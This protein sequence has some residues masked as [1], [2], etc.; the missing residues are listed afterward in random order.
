MKTLSTLFVAALFAFSM[1]GCSNMSKTGK[2]AVI[3]TG[4][5]A[6]AGAAIGKAAGDATKG[7]II[8]AVVGGSAGAIIGRQMDKQAAELEEE[9][10]NADVE[11]VGEGIQITFDSAIL[12]E[13]NS[14]DLSVTSEQN[15]R[16]LAQSLTDYP[17]TDILITGH[18]DATGSADYNQ[19]LSERRANAAAAFLLR[20]G[21]AESRIERVGY[22][23]STPI[24]SNDTEWGRQQNRRV[25]V[26]IYASEEYREELT[27]QQGG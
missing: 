21:I 23:E 3:G 19:D 5:G 12:F 14:S 26:A 16:N 8:G 22:G 18:T 17:N 2:G 6:A 4:A 9:L 24:A 25:E 1:M 15:L 10:E 13:T 20:H 11:R 7:A 27:N